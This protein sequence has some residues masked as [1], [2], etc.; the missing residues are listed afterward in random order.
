DSPKDL[1][2]I[3]VWY[4]P[5]KKYYNPSTYL[6][7]AER[8][9]LNEVI[10]DYQDLQN[11]YENFPLLLKKAYEDVLLAQN[12]CL[13]LAAQSRRP[14]L[15]NNLET[16][17]QDYELLDDTVSPFFQKINQIIKSNPDQEKQ[18]QQLID[19]FERDAVTDGKTIISKYGDKMCIHKLDKLRMDNDR[20]EK[21][22]FNDK[23]EC[24][25]CGEEITQNYDPRSW[26]DANNRPNINVG[27]IVID[28]VDVDDDRITGACQNILRGGET[29]ITFDN[30]VND[31]A[32]ELRKQLN[33]RAQP[34]S[35]IDSW[36]CQTMKYIRNLLLSQN[37]GQTLLNVI[38]NDDYLREII[39]IF[40]DFV[41][42]SEEN[43]NDIGTVTEEEI[44]RGFPTEVKEYTE[45]ALARKNQLISRFEADLNKLKE[46]KPT[47]STK[48]EAKKL[49]RI[50]KAV[51]DSNPNDEEAFHNNWELLRLSI[52]LDKFVKRYKLLIESIV[53]AFM[54]QNP[55]PSEIARLITDLPE[56]MKPT[57]LSQFA[58][59]YR[60]NDSQIFRISPFT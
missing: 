56:L 43:L 30:Y 27:S 25:I 16:K 58:N 32:E 7:L 14:K 44:A 1:L 53:K 29:S 10:K 60:I 55:S 18:N 37:K 13:S 41:E 9:S 23:G 39:R 33:S 57:K 59:T 22:Y 47:E 38:D 17:V 48:T 46:N 5:D 40:Q 8:D 26:D 52:K 36:I 34:L 28:P 11:I 12:K 15:I 31:N 35:E 54:D 19:L 20:F 4:T 24:K 45:Q 49:E 51:K 2:E 42:Y 3:G 6:L 21:E 50:L